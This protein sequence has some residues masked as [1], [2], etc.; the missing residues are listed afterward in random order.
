[1]VTVDGKIVSL[2]QISKFVYDAPAG[3]GHQASLNLFVRSDQL[4]QD[5]VQVLTEKFPDMEKVA[6]GKIAKIDQEKEQLRVITWCPLLDD[7]SK[8]LPLKISEFDYQ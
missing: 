1:M 6:T 4:V 5:T 8:G 7:L 2:I 3:A